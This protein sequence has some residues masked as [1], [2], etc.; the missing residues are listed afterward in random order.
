[1]SDS[2]YYGYGTPFDSK[3]QEV[4]R[5]KKLN[6]EREKLKILMGSCSRTIY[7]AYQPPYTC[8]NINK[9]VCMPSSVCGSV[10]PNSRSQKE[11]IFDQLA[12][13]NKK[14]TQEKIKLNLII[15]ELQKENYNLTQDKNKYKAFAEAEKGKVWK[16]L[17]K[18]IR[19]IYQKIVD[20]FNS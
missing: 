9:D 4:Q 6:E 13:E 14:L 16:D 18:S 8:A 3:D 1:M 15:L 20:W 5:I 12:K 19:S 7:D 11:T 2:S 17:N 10:S